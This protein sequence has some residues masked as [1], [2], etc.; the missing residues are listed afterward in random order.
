MWS[1]QRQCDE[2]CQHLV[3]YN[4]TANITLSTG[5][6]VVLQKII[7]ETRRLVPSN[8]WRNNE[9]TNKNNERRD[10]CG[11]SVNYLKVLHQGD[12]SKV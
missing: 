10:V 5:S 8:P 4:R 1:R 2:I 12:K 7:K 3:T 9:E 11:Y 6:S